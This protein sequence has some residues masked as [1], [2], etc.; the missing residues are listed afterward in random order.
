[1]LYETEFRVLYFERVDKSLSYNNSYSL[2]KNVG[3]LP[4]TILKHLPCSYKRFDTTTEQSSATIFRCL[5][6]PSTVQTFTPLFFNTEAFVFN[7]SNVNLQTARSGTETAVFLGPRRNRGEDAVII[8]L[9]MAEESFRYDGPG[10]REKFERDGG[11]TS[12][13]AVQE[14]KPPPLSRPLPP[15]RSLPP[16]PPVTKVVPLF[17]VAHADTCARALDMRACSRRVTGQP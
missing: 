11:K 8:S 5:V 4:S 13:H 7:R 14:K 17:R 1:M 3:Q 15:Y 6:S 10:A 12:G 9:S 16:S 2:H